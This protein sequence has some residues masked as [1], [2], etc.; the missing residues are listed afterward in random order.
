MNELSHFAI[1]TDQIE[2]AKSFYN[3]IFGWKFRD[4]GPA[5]FSQITTDAENE[6]KLIGALQSRDYA[7]IDQKIVGFECSIAVADLDLTIEKIQEHGGKI[8]MP[9]TA[10]PQVGELVKFLDTEGNLVCAV[11]YL[12]DS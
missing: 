4:Y 6:P 7:P 1:Y 9:K 12:E 2:R 10:I 5:D 3:H 11:Q 8:V